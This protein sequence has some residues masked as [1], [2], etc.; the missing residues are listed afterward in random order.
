[1][2]KCMEDCMA[3]PN[4][5]TRR[6]FLRSSVALG[7]GL[8]APRG[9]AAEPQD[10]A[11][12]NPPKP[13]QFKP[14]LA[15][16]V[17]PRRPAYDLRPA[18]VDKLRKAYAALRELT[19]KDPSDP[20]GWLQQGNK[21]CWQCGGGLDGKAG[22]EI[23]GGWL[24][25]PWHRAYLH[26]H[27]RILGKLIGDPSL[28][29]AYWDW[30]NAAHRAVP[31][32]W[33]TPNTPAANPL[34]DPIRSAVPG[35]QIPL[36]YVGPAAMNPIWGAPD[37]TTIGGSPGDN[38]G[39][40]VENTVHGLV[41][42][43]CGDTTLASAK[44]DMGLLDTAAQD[45]VFFAH[46]SNIDRIWSVWNGSSPSHTNPTDKPDWMNHTFNFWDENKQWVSIKISDVLDM[47]R[48]LRYN[49]G[50]APAAPLNLTATVSALK[51]T[52]AARDTLVIPEAA[53][54]RVAANAPGS[55]TALRMEGLSLPAGASGVYLIV[56]NKPNANA[57]EIAGTPNAV[58][59]VA[60]VPKTSTGAHAHAGLSAS[61]NL[62][63]HAELLK[64]SA[65][66]KFT[67]V[68]LAG[69]ASTPLRA[70]NVFLVE[71]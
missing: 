18:E 66:M 51:W 63:A 68:P 46:H 9:F 33:L 10:C 69:G 43:W 27:E 23:H 37:F 13:V 44:A 19:V 28:R 14:D 58:G 12:P 25:F 11:G 34:F 31:P 56:A 22:E 15:T 70:K 61:L 32:A 1:M 30:D 57:A 50:T 38:D 24:F 21:H 36:Q 26:F 2:L 64:Q 8:L 52:T 6:T 55:V 54:K 40:N 71:R 16:P 20:R 45:P 41:H 4:D 59:Y 49:Y 7:A 47:E 35:D 29:L 3:E 62:S 65:K 48:N 67:L 39:G 53:Q 17:R 5:R 42:I 60:I